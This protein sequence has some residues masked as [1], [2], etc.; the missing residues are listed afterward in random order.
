MSQE[1]TAYP[2]R[3]KQTEVWRNICLSKAGLENSCTSMSLL[4]NKRKGYFVDFISLLCQEHVPKGWS[5]RGNTK[6]LISL[7]FTV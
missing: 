7:H 6:K 4:C 2:C 1:N 5:S 3:A